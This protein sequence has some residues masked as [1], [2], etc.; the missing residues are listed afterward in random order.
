MVR[1]TVKQIR[2]S[3]GSFSIHA[4]EKD[5]RRVLHCVADAYEWVSYS[6]HDPLY[7]SYSSF[8]VS[9]SSCKK[10]VIS[11]FNLESC[12]S[13]SS[14]NV[15]VKTYKQNNCVVFA[16]TITELYHAHTWEGM[17]IKRFFRALNKR[18]VTY[19]RYDNYIKDW[20]RTI[21]SDPTFGSEV[22]ISA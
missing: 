13:C 2:L 17:S 10:G 1:D 15:V 20:V 5:L 18:Q 7:T 14:S 8:E 9:C 3:N 11:E 16:P 12:Q 19:L 6:W 22:T 21:D 4:P